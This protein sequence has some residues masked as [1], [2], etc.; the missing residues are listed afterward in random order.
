MIPLS[1][2]T[3]KWKIDSYHHR[4]LFWPVSQIVIQRIMHGFLVDGHILLQQVEISSS[5]VKNHRQARVYLGFCSRGGKCI[6][7]AANFKGGKSKSK[8]GNPHI[9]YREGQFPWGKPPP[10]PPPPPPRFSVFLFERAELLI[11]VACK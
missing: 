7:V 9:T 11:V 1:I 6:Y 10:P 4:R 8:G 3:K 2:Y 5:H